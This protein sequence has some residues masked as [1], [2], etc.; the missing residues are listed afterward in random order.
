MLEHLISTIRILTFKSS[1]FVLQNITAYLNYIIS[2]IGSCSCTSSLLTKNFETVSVN[3]HSSCVWSKTNK[4]INL[5]NS[6]DK[7]RKELYGKD[8]TLEFTNINELVIPNLSPNY[9]PT[10]IKNSQ[11]AY[12]ATNS[13]YSYSA[14]NAVYAC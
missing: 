8:I 12:Y 14:D 3:L 10:H 9:K 1:L 11:Y 2:Y 4:Y 13:I 5:K 6:H 7:N